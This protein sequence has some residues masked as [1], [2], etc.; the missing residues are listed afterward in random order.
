MESKGCREGLAPSIGSLFNTLFLQ[1]WTIFPGC[2]LPLPHLS[3]YSTLFLNLLSSFFPLH[4]LHLTSPI[5]SSLLL[6]FSLLI[7]LHLSLLL[8]LL[9][10][11]AKKG[12]WSVFLG[13]PQ[14]REKGN[15]FNVFH[16]SIIFKCPRTLLSYSSH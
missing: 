5:F 9:L 14:T 3:L 4:H 2:R 13:E 6:L 10:S 12:T 16:L 7:S 8:L 15:H 11:R 1:S